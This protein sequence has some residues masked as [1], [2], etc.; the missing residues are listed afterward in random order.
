MTTKVCLLGFTVPDAA[1]DEIVAVD[2]HMPSQ[3]HHFAWSLV[4]A[5]GVAGLQV[6]LLSVW[7]VSN[8]PGNPRIFFVLRPLRQWRHG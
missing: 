4:D 7:P 3:T 6:G 1:R 2:R 5:L 8:F